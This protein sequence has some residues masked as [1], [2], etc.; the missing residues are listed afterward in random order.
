MAST[1]WEMSRPA[2]SLLKNFKGAADDDFGLFWKKFLIVC[3][4]QKWSTEQKRM[5]HL[6]L[7]LEGEAFTVW[8]EID[9]SVQDCE[10]EV[11]RRF[12]E[13]FC[14]SPAQ[15]YRKFVG[16]VLRVD[17]SVDTFLADL[18]KLLRLSGHAEAHGGKDPLLIE[19]FMSGLPAGF[20][21]ELRLA[22]AMNTLTLEECVTR[23]RALRTAEMCSAGGG[24]RRERYTEVAAA[25]AQPADKGQER[26][27]QS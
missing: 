9:E 24:R 13:A 5:E 17:E 15:A 27:W 23:T 22:N 7:F 6:P 8:S 19:Q 18:R 25:A 11:K 20:A 14:M 10:D 26:R 2:E 12:S 16:R 1:A 21:K 4:I 3:K